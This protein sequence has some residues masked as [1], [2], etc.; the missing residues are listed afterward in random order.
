MSNTNEPN[1]E[2]SSGI[3]AFEGK[4]FAMAMQLLSPLAAAGH[5][6]AR[7]RVAIMQQNGLLG[8]ANVQDAA[9]GM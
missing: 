8:S 2:L 5:A 4:H 7:Y 3:A 9:K 6:E 1:M